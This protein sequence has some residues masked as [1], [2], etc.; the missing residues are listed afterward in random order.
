MARDEGEQL[1]SDALLRR[2]RHGRLDGVRTGMSAGTPSST[3]ATCSGTAEAGHHRGG[4][5]GS[6]VLAPRESYGGDYHPE[7]SK[8][9][10]DPKSS[11]G[12]TGGAF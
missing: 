4:G 12:D 1:E 3:V 5:M 11:G 9:K 10:S 7:Q 2:D 6:A 8:P